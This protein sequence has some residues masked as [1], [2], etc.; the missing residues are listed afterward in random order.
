MATTDALGAKYAE[1]VFRS[2]TTSAPPSRVRWNRRSS[3][4][5]STSSGSGRPLTVACRGRATIESPCE[6]SVIASTSTGE[7]P[8]SSAMKKRRRAESRTPAIPRTRSLGN[9]LRSAARKVISSSG[10]DTTI[11]MALG[12]LGTTFATTSVMIAAFLPSR[13]IRLMPGWRGNPAVITT[14]SEPAVSA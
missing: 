10:F 4:G 1:P 12:E 9:P 2:A 13:S 3:V 5:W 8:S 7:T 11:R 6:P 14:M